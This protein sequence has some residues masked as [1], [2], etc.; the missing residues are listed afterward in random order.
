MKPLTFD[1]RPHSVGDYSLVLSEYTAG[2]GEILMTQ[3]FAT[4]QE[5]R[6]EFAK[7]EQVIAKAKTK[8]LKIVSA[9]D[10]A[11]ASAV[12]VAMAASGNT[13]A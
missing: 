6:E 11:I 12:K 3:P 2:D 9:P 8:A 1:L 7:L 10:A 13:P 4:E 5:C